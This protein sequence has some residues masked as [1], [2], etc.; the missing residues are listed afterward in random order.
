MELTLGNASFT[1]VVVERNGRWASHAVRVD[2]G[3]RFGI[4]VSASSA[5]EA[6]DRLRRWLQWQHRHESALD[7]LQQAERAYHRAMAGSAFGG[8]SSETESA[9]RK[10]S[11]EAMK[12]AR[13]QLDDLRAQRPNV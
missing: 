13:A 4:E 3:Q 1:L 5:Q 8:S 9:E 12:S 11:L 10:N 2:D 6:L 7:E